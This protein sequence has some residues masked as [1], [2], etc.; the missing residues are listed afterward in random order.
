MSLLAVGVHFYGKPSIKGYVSARSFYPSPKVDSTI[1]RIDI[2]KRPLVEVEDEEQFFTVVRAGFS[3]PRKQLRNSL[4]QG[5]NVAS[6]DAE[7]LLERAGI[8]SQRRAETL[9]VQEWAAIYR[10]WL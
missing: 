10:V 4:A 2:Y 1:L 6:S 7:V 9:S 3:A 8:D 5:L